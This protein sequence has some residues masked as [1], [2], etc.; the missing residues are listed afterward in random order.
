MRGED[1]AEGGS[2]AASFI[3]L[4]RHSSTGVQP[5][6]RLESGSKRRFLSGRISGRRLEIA[7]VGLLVVVLGI[8]MFWDLPDSVGVLSMLDESDAAT[9]TT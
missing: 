1:C 2:S 6:L 4:D 9:P 8:V 7:L 5:Q 3:A